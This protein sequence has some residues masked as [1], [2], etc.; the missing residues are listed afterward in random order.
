MDGCDP[1]HGVL[2]N[3]YTLLYTPTF[4]NMRERMGAKTRKTSTEVWNTY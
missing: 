2:L 1:I 4:E 3:L